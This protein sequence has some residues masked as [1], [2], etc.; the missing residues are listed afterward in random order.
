MD[1]RA[2]MLSRAE[3]L[4]AAVAMALE[5]F[6]SDPRAETAAEC[7]ALRQ[8][9]RLE[10]FQHRCDDALLL[11]FRAELWGV[12]HDPKA[13][14][15]LRRPESV[16]RAKALRAGM[17]AVALPRKPLSRYTDADVHD[18]AAEIEPLLDSLPAPLKDRRT[19]LALCEFFGAFRLALALVAA[20]PRPLKDFVLR[21]AATAAVG[22]YVLADGPLLALE[23][24]EYWARHVLAL[25]ADVHAR[26]AEL[27]T[28]APEARAALLQGMRRHLT[29][30]RS[31][32]DTFA[33]MWTNRSYGA[34]IALVQPRD[35]D[36]AAALPPQKTSALCVGS[37]VMAVA[38]PEAHQR[39]QTLIHSI[40][41]L[42]LACDEPSDEVPEPPEH[43]PLRL[44]A[45]LR[46]LTGMCELLGLA[47][48][49]LAPVGWGDD[50]VMHAGLRFRP[51][52]P[53]ERGYVLLVSGALVVASGEK[54]YVCQDYAD[55]AL[56][57]MRLASP[58]D[59]AR[60]L[61][62]SSV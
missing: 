13:A 60:R 6:Q 15:M 39:A 28:P 52:T 45:Q 57:L 34:S 27:F 41:Y 26:G 22:G 47:T 17:A 16:W 18:I 19:H 55:A 62:V 46:M 14:G 25:Q 59:A 23:V 42:A 11:L 43:I 50:T 40:D 35:Y 54:T 2:D 31:V 8:S 21:S 44:Y 33:K 56:L 1:M 51:E 12:L 32:R 10:L 49:Q 38:R 3:D 29:A 48:E 20:R 5:R 37:E 61:H 7:A 30:R 4:R 36:I 24:L 58:A 9:R 53:T